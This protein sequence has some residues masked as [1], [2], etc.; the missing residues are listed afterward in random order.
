MP[1]DP[2]SSP[3]SNPFAT[4]FTRPSAGD[5]LFPA[6]ADA[7]ALLAR[8]QEANW[9][10]QITGPH[11][12]GKSTLVYTLMPGLRAAGRRVE[13]Y[14]LHQP[15][16]VRPGPTLLQPAGHAAGSPTA[17]SGD[18]C[19]KGPSKACW[20]DGVAD[21]NASTQIVLD[22][23]EQLT[24]WQRLRLRWHCRRRGAGLLVTAHRDLGLPPL[25]RTETN[26]ELAQRLVARLLGEGNADWPGAERVERLLA[27]HRGNLREVLF[28]LY[29][30]YEHPPA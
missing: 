14:S 16:S 2:P 26:A 9:W 23:C 8:L 10:G 17:I 21:W 28:A 11:G 20:R 3:P 4:R 24:W 30:L 6:G 7:G 27:E 25:W 22:G 29:D 5:Y 12:T 18:Y 19:G 15:A 13:F 1:S